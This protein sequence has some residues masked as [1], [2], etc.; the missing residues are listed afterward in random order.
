[1][2]SISKGLPCEPACREQPW[3]RSDCEHHLECLKTLSADEVL[4]NVRARLPDLQLKDASQPNLQLGDSSQ[5][6]GITNMNEISLVY[7]A[8]VFDASGYGHAARAYIHA[9]HRAGIRLSVVDLGNHARQVRDELVESLLNK[10]LQPDFHLFHGIPPYWARF[11]F[12]LNNAIGMTVWET[13]VMPSQWRN[14][15]N[16]VLE[17]WLP[18]DYNVKVFG[19]SL[20]R[21]VFKLP[22]PILPAEVNGHALSAAQFPSVSEKDFVFYSIFEW[23]ERKSPEQM[24]EAYLRAFA[25]ESETV[26][27]VKANPGAK[28][29]A[30]VALE[31]ARRETRST[32]R[33]E[34]RCEAWSGSQIEALHERGDCYVSLHRGEGWC[35]PLFD[36]ASRGTPVLATNYSGPLEYL[37]AQDHYLVKFQL[38]AVRQPYIYYHPKMRWAEPDIAHASELMRRVFADREQARTQ[39]KRAAQSLQEAY[40]L[41]AIGETA[42]QRLIQLLRNKQPDKWRQLKKNERAGE[43]TPA[44]PIPARWYDEH[45]FE[46]GIKSN[47]EQGYTWQI[48]SSLFRET[49]LF[50]T[51]TFTEAHSFLDIGSAKGFLVRALRE[52]GKDSFGFDFSPW[53]IEHAEQSVKPYLSCVSVDDACFDRQFDVLTAFS[54]FETLTEEQITS[55]LS[56]ARGWTRQALVATI[57]SFQ[58]DEE[59]RHYKRNDQDL[60]HI[61]MRTHQWWHEKFLSTGWR[62]DELHRIVQRLCQN[63]YLPT[64]MNWRVYVYVPA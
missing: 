55:F 22:H 52:R 48:F 38:G 9:L 63:H 40:S 39:A 30:R 42:K 41:A 61:T 36:A 13:D 26:L 18:C 31:R 33:V 2:F 46:N 29:V 21:P 49:A 8:N 27:I 5:S 1:M 59:E 15:L 50:L 45:Y 10:P 4:Q 25:D 56:R 53:A 16:H 28:Q 23:Q 37:N 17:V 20:E 62:Q 32:A 47:W 54:I 60:S 35:Y 57:P 58:N 6:D 12:R 7:Y 64:R 19:K 11:A 14:A 44:V 43:L 51:E 34:L 24:L 3:G